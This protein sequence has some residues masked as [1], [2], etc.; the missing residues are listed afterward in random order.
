MRRKDY[1]M[2]KQQMI[3]IMTY[4]FAEHEV[5]ISEERLAVWFDQFK[6]VDVETAKLA[7]KAMTSRKSFGIPKAH[8]FAQAISE[9]QQIGRENWGEAWDIFRKLADKHGRYQYDLIKSEFER[10]SPTGFL[11]MGTSFKEY[12]D[13]QLDQLNTFKAQFRQRFEGLQDRDVR[14]SQIHPEVK[15]AL[16]LDNHSQT[17]RIEQGGLTPIGNII[18][19]INFDNLK[20]LAEKKDEK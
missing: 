17:K 11:A 13:L 5:V 14:D 3:D 10:L 7:A 15:K 2:K 12:F 9:V 18:A 6:D 20:N 16:G 19:G 8:D 4:V 1:K